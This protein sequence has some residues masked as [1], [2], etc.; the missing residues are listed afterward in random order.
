VSDLRDI[1]ERKRAEA[2]PTP[3]AFE[4]L[5]TRRRRRDFRRR[6]TAGTAALLVVVVGAIAA[7]RLLPTKTEPASQPVVV[8]TVVLDRTPAVM[9][10]GLGSLWVAEEPRLSAE[11]AEFQA[12]ERLLQLDPKTGRVTA[13]VPLAVAASGSAMEVG[14]GAVWLGGLGTV[15]RIDPESGA[16]LDA[17]GF[18]GNPTALGLARGEPE[19]SPLRGV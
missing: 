2:R 19:S 3:G 1:L 6:A 10:S 13:E 17:F 14:E 11:G 15:S 16:Q 4:R 12:D 8:G 18:G 5:D 9:A 7:I